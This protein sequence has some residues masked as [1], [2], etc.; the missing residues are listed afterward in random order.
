ME[1][2][3]EVTNI[4]VENVQLQVSL[5]VIFWRNFLERFWNPENLNISKSIHHE[6]MSDTWIAFNYQRKSLQK[7]TGYSLIPRSTPLLPCYQEWFK[8]YYTIRS[9][10]KNIES[11]C[12]RGLVVKSSDYLQIDLISYLG[13]TTNLL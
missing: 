6:Y 4:L 10:L 9:V 12:F 7:R 13:G 11:M 3:Q 1:R 8:W 5:A 2:L